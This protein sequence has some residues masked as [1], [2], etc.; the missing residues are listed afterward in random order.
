MNYEKLPKILNLTTRNEKTLWLLEER[1]NYVAKEESFWQV[2]L[3]SAG[4]LI[5]NKQQNHHFNVK[6]SLLDTIGE[7]Q[8]A[9]FIMSSGAYNYQPAHE[10]IYTLRARNLDFVSIG[11]DIEPLSDS[12]IKP[13]IKF[14][15]INLKLEQ[16]VEHI[17]QSDSSR[18]ILAA[19]REKR[20]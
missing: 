1:Q 3:L 18:A 15:Y 8:L 11:I 17:G 13:E 2:T 19:K 4:I 5:D 20:C 7:I 6:I 9:N 16:N 14:G 10:A 12:S